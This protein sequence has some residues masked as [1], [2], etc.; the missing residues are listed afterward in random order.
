[1]HYLEYRLRLTDDEAAEL[2]EIEAV[3]DRR[4]VADLQRT[5]WGSGDVG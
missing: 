5:N 2:T 1:M 3:V 4:L